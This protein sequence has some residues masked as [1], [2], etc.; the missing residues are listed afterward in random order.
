MKLITKSL[1]VTALSMAGLAAV[2]TQAPHVQAATVDVTN[3]TITAPSVAVWD[4]IEN[5]NFTGRELK[6]NTTW[7]V[8]R[9]AYDGRGNKWFDLGNNQWILAKYTD[10]DSHES[11]QTHAEPTT[12]NY[13]QQ[14][15]PS[16]PKQQATQTYQSYV[17]PVQKQQAVQ[18]QQ[19][20][21]APVQKQ[22]AVQPQQSYVAPAQKQQVVQSQVTDAPS[23]TSSVEESAKA[24][25]ANHESGGSYS[26]RNG[27]FIGKYQLSAS[28]LGGDY[29]AE[30]QERVANNY[31]KGRY[32]SWAGAQQFWQIHG[33]Y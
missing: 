23:A 28:Y 19:S 12:S 7:K 21:V 31:V 16:Q 5:A 24:W 26:A 33:W 17:A 32:G 25:I 14:V 8:I 1:T 11:N 3:A 18:S 13:A 6:A 27:Q 30:N 20:Y 10:Q 9:T 4:G 29:S 2:N 22:Q 15:T